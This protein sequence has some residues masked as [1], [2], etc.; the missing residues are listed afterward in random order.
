LGF[1]FFGDD[2]CEWLTL[3]PK[4]GPFSQI[5][6]TFGMVVSLSPRFEPPLYHI[7]G[8]EA[9]RRPHALTATAKPRTLGGGAGMKRSVLPAVLVVLAALIAACAR[10]AS[11]GPIAA[12]VAAALE[13]RWDEAARYWTAAVESD[14]R[15]AAAH[16]NLAIA[17]ERAGDWDGAG[18][19]YDEALRLAPENPDIKANHESFRLRLGAGRKKRP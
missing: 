13:G 1:H 11:P 17:L 2:L 9:N 6:H 4:I 10:P 14:P 18:R 16:N 12:G 3:C 5:S 15:S 19:E 7:Y 8:R